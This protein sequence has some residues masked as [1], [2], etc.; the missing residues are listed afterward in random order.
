[1]RFAAAKHP[2]LPDVPL[3]SDLAPSVQARAAL[4]LILT[5]QV[6][7]RPL[8]APPQVPRARVAALRQAFEQTLRD[9]KFLAE[10]ERLALE[11]D[12]VPGETLQVMVERMFGSPRDVVE[13]ARRAIGQ[14]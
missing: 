13:A 1:V 12:L 2:E 9:P 14:R 5:Q 10:A 11:I 7:G 3:A 8:A 4:E 6:M